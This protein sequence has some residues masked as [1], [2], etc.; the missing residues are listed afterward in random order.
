[1][2]KLTF[3]A[4]QHLAQLFKELGIIPQH[5][6]KWSLDYGREIYTLLNGLR[7]LTSDELADL[8]KNLWDEE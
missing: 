1:M 7:D 3:E 5:F 8:M 2:P 6:Q 4:E